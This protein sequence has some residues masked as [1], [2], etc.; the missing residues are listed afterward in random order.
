MSRKVCGLL[1][2]RRRAARLTDGISRPRKRRHGGDVHGRRKHVVRRLAHVDLIVGMDLAAHA[3]LAAQE[4]AGAVGDDLVHV[5]VRLRAAA[6]LPDDQ[7]KLGVVLAGDH[8][9]GRRR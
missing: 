2:Q 6:G 5:H 8:L 7:G 1:G 9:V 4:L 3:A